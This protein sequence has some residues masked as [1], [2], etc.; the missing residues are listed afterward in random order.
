A[1]TSTLRSND[2]GMSTMS[3]D[4]TEMSRKV[5]SKHPDRSSYQFPLY[6]NIPENS[7]F[8]DKAVSKTQDPIPT[9]PWTLDTTPTSAWPPEKWIR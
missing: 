1:D 8:F 3:A 9:C 7:R 4:P 5:S 6:T 2:S